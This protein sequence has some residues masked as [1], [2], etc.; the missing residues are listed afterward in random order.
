MILSDRTIRRYLDYR[1]GLSITPLD[2]REQIQPSSID[3]RLDCD[4]VNLH[5]RKQQTAEQLTFHPGQFYLASTLESVQLPEN[6]C[7]LLKGRSSIG[8][9]GII[10]IT[11]GWVD[12]GFKG[13]LTLEVVNFGPSPVTLDAGTRICQ[14]VLMK[15]DYNAEVPYNEKDD[16]KYTGQTGPT[17]SKLERL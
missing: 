14:L 5:A 10:P 8:R 7:G 6:V 13:Q 11:A 1:K 3:L 4:I 9:L 2:K 15:M 12:A 16:Q 17:Q